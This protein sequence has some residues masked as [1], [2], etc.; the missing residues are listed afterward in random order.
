MRKHQVDHGLHAERSDRLHLHNAV[1]IANDVKKVTYVFYSQ[2]GKS[3]IAV[4]WCC[5]D[6]A[7]TGQPH[8][9]VD[10]LAVYRAACKTVREHQHR[11]ASASWRC[12]ENGYARLAG[13]NGGLPAALHVWDDLPIG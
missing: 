5:H 13:E 8:Q 2:A 10:R 12:R 11:P 4:K 3:T 7:V 1:K 9:E 6:V